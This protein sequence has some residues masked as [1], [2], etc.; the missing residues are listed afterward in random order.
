MTAF[1][2]S[3]EPVLIL[4]LT[5]PVGIGI[6]ITVALTIAL[7]AFVMRWRQVQA[8]RQIVTDLLRP[9]K[10]VGVPPPTSGNPGD[11]PS[12]T[13][14]NGR[15][16]VRRPPRD[17]N[18]LGF[19]FGRAKWEIGTGEI[20]QILDDNYDALEP[21]RAEV[22]SVIVWRQDGAFYHVGLV[23]EVS[24]SGEPARIR[25]KS[26]SSNYVFDHT[27]TQAPYSA[28]YVVYRRRSTGGL[29]PA[30]QAA[31]ARAQ[32]AY[33]QVMD[34]TSREAHDRAEELCQAR[35]ALINT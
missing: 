32:V 24:A 15:T 12:D 16:F 26:A 20:D 1:G 31:L 27:A 21:G 35:N 22:C 6:G 2:T 17:Y 7:I 9:V 33:A 10:D 19:T 28:E 34:K 3:V 25:S 18:C 11:T 30:D 5:V 23:I 8:Q 13:E 29:S 14:R 4:G